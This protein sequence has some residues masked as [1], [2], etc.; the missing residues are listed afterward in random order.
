MSTNQEKL[1]GFIARGLLDPNCAGCTESIQEVLKTGTLPM[2]PSHQPKSRC[3]SG[4]RPHCTC[5][6][7][8]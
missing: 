6:F 4:N 3:R 2:A 8:W 5:D 7:C 1:Q